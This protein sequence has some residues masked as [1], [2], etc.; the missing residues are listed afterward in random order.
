M[1][2]LGTTQAIPRVWEMQVSVG[3]VMTMQLDCL[4]LTVMKER[5]RRAAD[6]K[7]LTF[8][9]DLQEQINTFENTLFNSIN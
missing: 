6:I 5:P 7:P 9:D 1:E 4:C 3:N 2:L 8:S